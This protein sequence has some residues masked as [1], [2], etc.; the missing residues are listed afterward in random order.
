M[1]RRIETMSSA[2][3]YRLSGIILLIGSLLGGFGS[4][5]HTVLFP[6]N[7]PTAQ[8]ILE[9]P[10]ILDA[11]LF[12]CWALLLALSLPAFYLRQAARAGAMGATGLVLFLLGILQ[13]GVAFANAQ[14]VVFPYLAQSAPALLPAGGTGPVAGF[15]LWI[16]LPP[17]LVASGAIL[18]G[19]ATRRAH[20]FPGG[21]GVL[22]ISSG[23]LML[24]SLP[25]LPAPFGAIISLVANVT[26]FIAFG[27]G[28]YL[29]ITG[30][31]EAAGAASHPATQ[32]GLSGE[33]NAKAL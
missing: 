3:L 21:T 7:N 6:E 11:V 10:F 27:W 1:I 31:R 25:P 14:L 32:A 26:F 17:L 2:T 33:S 20:V 19:V 5:L 23:V 16:A 18:L 13:G 22:L 8:Q 4:I 15:L 12:L 28:A 24:L 29:L 9:T 30:A